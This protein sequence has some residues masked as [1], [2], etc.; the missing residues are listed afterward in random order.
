VS[1]LELL[2]QFANN[3]LGRNC[4]SMQIE[5]TLKKNLAT[6]TS[7]QLKKKTVIFSRIRTDYKNS[8]DKTKSLTSFLN[9]TGTKTFL[10]WLDVNDLQLQCLLWHWFLV[11]IHSKCL[12]FFGGGAEFPLRKINL[13]TFWGSNRWRCWVTTFPPVLKAPSDGAKVAT[14]PNICLAYIAS[15]GK[16]YWHPFTK[17]YQALPFHRQII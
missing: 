15:R 17:T 1:F 6:Q 5:E 9:V 2:E 4:S 16:S 10:Y 3:C 12:L 14:I 13:S 7:L 11:R 8:R